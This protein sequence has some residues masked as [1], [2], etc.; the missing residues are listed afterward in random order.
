L[1]DMTD[2]KFKNKKT[3]GY[4]SKKEAEIAANLWALAA[5]GEIEDLKEQVKFDLI[6]GKNGVR[7][8][9]YIADFTFISDNQLHVVDVKP[10]DKKNQKFRKTPEFR[11]KE[12]MM[13]LLLGITVQ[14]M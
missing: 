11:L 8:I 3:N 13:F 4:D 2:S 1:L 6:P 5:S 9:S 10:F 7:G 14:L 12:K